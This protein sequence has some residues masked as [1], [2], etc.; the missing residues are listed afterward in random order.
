MG[1]ETYLLLINVLIEKKSDKIILVSFPR[2]EPLTED[3]IVEIGEKVSERC[4]KFEGK[5]L[6]ELKNNNKIFNK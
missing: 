1:L 3:L 6:N 4:F 5:L 2:F